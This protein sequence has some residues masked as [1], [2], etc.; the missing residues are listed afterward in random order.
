[1]TIMLKIGCRRSWSSNGNATFGFPIR[2]G[3]DVTGVIWTILGTACPHPC[4]IHKDFIPTRVPPAKT[5][6]E[7]RNPDNVSKWHVTL[8]WPPIILPYDLYVDSP[9]ELRTGAEPHHNVDETTC[10]RLH[11]ST[12]MV[13][14]SNKFRKCLNKISDITLQASAWQNFSSSMESIWTMCSIGQHRA[15]QNATSICNIS[16]ATSLGM[17]YFLHR[18][19]P[20]N[21]S[22][23][24]EC[25][26]DVLTLDDKPTLS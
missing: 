4:L 11:R 8:M 25:A 13:S 15:S 12:P 17:A 6:S 24:T 7:T 18:H 3:W 16:L 23:L 10:T 9:T 20:I 21:Q 1:M 5:E 26:Y 14:C 19:L 22:C 2:L